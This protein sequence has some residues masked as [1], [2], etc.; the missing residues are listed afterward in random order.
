MSETYVTTTE[1]VLSQ[2]LRPRDVNKN[3]RETQA[4]RGRAGNSCVE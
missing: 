2:L 4:A 1:D 3:K